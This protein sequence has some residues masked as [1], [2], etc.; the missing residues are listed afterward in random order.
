MPSTS[1]RGSIPVET[2][3][4]TVLE[5][6]G[7]W[8]SFYGIQRVIHKHACELKDNGSA[9]NNAYLGSYIVYLPAS[10][11]YLHGKVY[12][13]SREKFPHPDLSSCCLVVEVIASSETSFFS[14]R[15][16]FLIVERW[17]PP[18]RYL[19]ESGGRRQHSQI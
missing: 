17:V 11:Y 18:S 1:V 15:S 7:I 2:G 16:A 9:W 4:A 13:L 10:N 3:H 5:I 19:G 6:G 12:G 14:P 8:Q